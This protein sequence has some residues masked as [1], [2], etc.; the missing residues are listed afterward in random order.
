MAGE[1]EGEGVVLWEELVVCEAVPSDVAVALV[2]RVV[3]IDH[4]AVGCAVGSSF[5]PPCDPKKSY[6]CASKSSS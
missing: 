4:G 2:E 5:S 6:D 1:V 3:A